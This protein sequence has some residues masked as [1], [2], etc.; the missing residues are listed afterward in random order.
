M[1]LCKDEKGD[2]NHTVDGL[3]GAQEDPGDPDIPCSFGTAHS[4]KPEITLNPKPKTLNPMRTIA[5]RNFAEARQSWFRLALGKKLARA[6]HIS[7]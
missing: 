7:L 5:R 1:D 3:A 4:P 6:T 2:L